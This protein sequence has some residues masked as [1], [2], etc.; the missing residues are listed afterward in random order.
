MLRKTP[1]R[2]FNQFINALRGFDMWEDEEE[3]AQQN[4]NMSFSAQKGRGIGNYSQR[5]GNNNFNSRG[6]G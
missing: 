3:V 4:H 5:R 1:Y 6:T 2:T